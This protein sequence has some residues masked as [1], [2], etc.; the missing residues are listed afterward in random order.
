MIMRGDFD[1]DEDPDFE[2]EWESF[3]D[4]EMCNDCQ[5][6]GSMMDTCNVCGMAMCSGCFEMG[7]GVCR[8]PHK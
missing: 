6:L 1:E 3:D 7:A 4:E 2:P 5:R 8:G